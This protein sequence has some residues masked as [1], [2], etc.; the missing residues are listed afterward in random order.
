M[1]EDFRDRAAEVMDRIFVMAALH[2]SGGTPAGTQGRCYEKE[3]LAGPVTELGSAMAIALGGAFRPGYDR[4]AAL[5]CLSDYAPPDVR[6]LAAPPEGRRVEA[7]YTQG[8][9]HLGRLTVWK[10]AEGQLA[11]V[12]DLGTGGPGHQAQVVD[13]QLAR[14]P[15]ARLWINHPGELKPWG[16]RRPSLLAGNHVMPRVAQEGPVALLIWDLDRP[17]TQIPLTQAF[18]APGA[19]GRPEGAGGWLLFAGTV[20]VWCSLPL[21]PVTTGLYRDALWRAEG[22][23]AGWVVAL[24]TPGET[25]AAFR[26]RL[27]A[28]R[29]G[30]DAEALALDATGLGPEPLALAFDGPLRVGGVPRPFAPL[31]PEPEVAWDGGAPGS[32]RERLSPPPQPA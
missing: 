15:M 1:A 13:V 5:L 10:S 7:R 31:S 28:A 3:L 18:A 26:K 4:A 19:F 29:V 12:T 30:F 25:A 11:T 21:A 2:T 27:A 23:R 22:R 14:H 6:A 32:W 8:L 9:G 24:R 20:G 17:W 16:D